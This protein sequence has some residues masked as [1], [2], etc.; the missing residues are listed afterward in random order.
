M[1]SS[2]QSEQMTLFLINK[3]KTQKEEHDDYSLIVFILRFLFFVVG[4]H[5]KGT[6][7]SFK[8][9]GAPGVRPLRDGGGGGAGLTPIPLV[10]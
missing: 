3:W 9:S 8:L 6:M 4:I 1:P 7:F 2:D 5:T 10:V